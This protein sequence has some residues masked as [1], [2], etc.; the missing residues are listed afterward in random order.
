M[1]VLQSYL[2]F[3]DPHGWARQAP[4]SVEFSRQEYCTGLPFPSA[5][6][7]PDIGIESGSPAL[8]ADSLLCESPGI[9]HGISINLPRWAGKFVSIV[10]YFPEIKCFTLCGSQQALI[11]SPKNM[12]VEGKTQNLTESLA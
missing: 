9:S 11:L 6:D 1:L 5:G 10:C 2:T 7:L 3:C 8:Q 12:K 4:L